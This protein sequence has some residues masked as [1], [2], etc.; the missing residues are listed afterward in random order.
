MS[1]MKLKKDNLRP[2]RVKRVKKEFVENNPEEMAL[3]K[4]ASDKLLE[5]WR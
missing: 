4:A 1:E 5:I 2:E 3:I